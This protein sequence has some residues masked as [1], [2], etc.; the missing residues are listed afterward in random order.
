MDAVFLLRLAVPVPL[1]QGLSQTDASFG[2]L[3]FSSYR[4]LSCRPYRQGASAAPPQ[5]RGAVPARRAA[6]STAFEPA[7]GLRSSPSTRGALV[8]VAE[9]G[10][11]AGFAGRRHL[12][13]FMAAWH[14][15]SVYQADEAPEVITRATL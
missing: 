15:K 2:R 7:R 12:A 14:L 6:A 13:L 10:A 3:P 1:H 9:R 8:A 11:W 4:L 5:E